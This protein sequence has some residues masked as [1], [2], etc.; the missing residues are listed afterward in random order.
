VYL[1]PSQ[2]H[3][4]AVMPGETPI[5]MSATLRSTDGRP[6]RVLS[7]DQSDFLKVDQTPVA[8]FPSPPASLHSLAL[9]LQGNDGASKRFLA[10]TVRIRVDRQEC[11][12][13]LLP[14]SAA[15]RERGR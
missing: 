11:P 8:A 12:E 5:R 14:W 2:V 15:V 7:I 9:R 3:F 13:V 1:S 10:G 6:F 4:D